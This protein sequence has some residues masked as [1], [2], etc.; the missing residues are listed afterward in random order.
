MTK[1]NWSGERLETFILNESTVEHLHRY[2]FSIAYANDKIVLDVACGEGY[3]SNLLSKHAKQVHGVDISEN[4]INHA[5]NKYKNNNLNFHI[6]SV[7]NLPFEDGTFDLVISF[8]TIE[9]ITEHDAMMLEIKRVLKGDGLLI[10]STPDKYF[11]SDIKSYKNP[12]HA[13]E[14][15]LNEFKNLIENYFINKIL[16]GQRSGFYSALISDSEISNLQ[17]YN[18]NYEN[19][20]IIDNWSPVYWIALAS[21]KKITINNYNSLFIG[22]YVI[23]EIINRIKS[24]YSYRIGNIIV[25]IFSP[26]KIPLK[27]IKQ[28]LTQIAKYKQYKI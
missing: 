26:L 9:H 4:T 2:A 7:T 25:Q 21:N 6:G 19:I 14:L 5:I 11:Y 22:E 16:I 18:G 27:Y 1:Q 17:I 23:N 8:E 13:K 20:S 3:G 28:K 10:I 15:Y 24:S 12:F